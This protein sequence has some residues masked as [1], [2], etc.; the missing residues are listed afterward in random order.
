M[1]YSWCQGPGTTQ[2]DGFAMDRSEAYSVV[3][4]QVLGPAFYALQYFK[5]NCQRADGYLE[6]TKDSLELG[7]YASDL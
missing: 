3:T 2:A 1:F 6:E 4:G 5:G 7:L